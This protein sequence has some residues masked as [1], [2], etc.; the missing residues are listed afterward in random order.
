MDIGVI[1]N[2]VKDKVMFQKGLSKNRNWN[3][4]LLKPAECLF[5]SKTWKKQLRCHTITKSTEQKQPNKN[6]S[7]LAFKW[8]CAKEL[9][10]NYGRIF[11]ILQDKSARS[12]DRNT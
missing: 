12:E 4:M 6:L 10:L 3:I 8:H 7:V 1:K 9:A 11:R 5:Y 2:D